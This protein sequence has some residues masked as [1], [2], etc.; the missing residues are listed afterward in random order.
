MIRRVFIAFIACAAGVECIKYVV[1]LIKVYNKVKR[2][3]GP[4]AYPIIGNL[5]DVIANLRG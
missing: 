5:L 4:K 3:P 2:I 1:Q